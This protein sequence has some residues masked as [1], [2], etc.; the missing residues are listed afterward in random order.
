M[1]RIGMAV[2]L[3]VEAC[4]IRVGN[5]DGSRACSAHFQGQCN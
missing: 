5:L 3:K 1:G 4:Q 2:E